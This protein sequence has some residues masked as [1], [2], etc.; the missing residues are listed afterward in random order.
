MK[1]KF[2]IAQW[3]PEK[4]WGYGWAMRVI[5]S[6][7]PRFVENSRFDFGFLNIASEEGYKITILPLPYGMKKEER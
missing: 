5:R 3:V 6:S 7:H 2:I 4:R 1:D